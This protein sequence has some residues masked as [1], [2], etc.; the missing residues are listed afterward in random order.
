M[1]GILRCAME[2]KAQKDP[3]TADWPHIANVY[4]GWLEY[5]IQYND[6][7]FEGRLL[8]FR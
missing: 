7:T 5:L 2:V 1:G 6:G 4:R 8:G 3:R